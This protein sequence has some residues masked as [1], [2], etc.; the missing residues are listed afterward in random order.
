MGQEGRGLFWS[1][2]VLERAACWRYGT[3]YGTPISQAGGAGVFW[4]IRALERRNSGSLHSCC[5]NRSDEGLAHPRTRAPQQWQS[6]QLL[7]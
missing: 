2:P 1:I 6:S 4:S 5:F 3:R 7:F